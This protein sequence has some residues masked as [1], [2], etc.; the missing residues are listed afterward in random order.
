MI[1]SIMF[2][3]GWLVMILLTA[4]GT[5]YV[6]RYIPSS[7]ASSETIIVPNDVEYARILKRARQA[8]GDA[9]VDILHVHI[10][11]ASPDG[12]SGFSNQD[13]LDEMCDGSF[14]DG[15]TLG[16]IVM[17][18][19]RLIDDPIRLELVAKHEMG[20]VLQHQHGQSLDHPNCNDD[21]DKLVMCNPTEHAR[22]EPADID[23][24]LDRI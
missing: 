5:T 4:C 24:V 18:N 7:N 6:D 23:F 12:D 10:L 14:I 21:L 11:D 17:L 2:K 1:G 8:W 15:C 20:H 9:G 3:H 16:H 19:E 22:I 13:Q